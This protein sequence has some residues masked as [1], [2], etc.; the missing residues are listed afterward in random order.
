MIKIVQIGVGPLG[1]KVV[2][3]ALQ[4][5]GIKIVAAV[6]PDPQKAGKDLGEIC[7]EGT[8]GINIHKTLDEALSGISPDAAVVTTLSSLKKVAGQI[9]ELAAA[10]LSVVSTC[11][12]LSFPWKTQPEI[13]ERIDEICKKY[14]VACLGT[15]VNPGFLMDYLPAVFTSVCQSVE[16]VVVTRVQDASRRR[17]PFQQKIGAGLTPEQFEVKEKEGALRHVGLPESIYMIGAALNWKL[18]RVEESLEPVLAEEPISSGYTPIE[19]G[20]PVGVEQIG[21]G[22]VGGRERITLRFRAAVGE[23]ESYDKVEI[24]GTPSFS[25]VITGG[26]NGD[27]ATSAITVNA[28]ASIIKKEP[29]LKTMLEIPVPAYFKEI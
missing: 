6:D 14:G 18:E 3:Y 7:G 17:I 2:R 9:E 4:R 15:G 16:S 24:T 20:N 5:K 12:E 10:G 1:Q 22:F 29:G 8:L 21:R 28:L 13:A 26:I 25:S 27:I 19:N 23:G 11:E